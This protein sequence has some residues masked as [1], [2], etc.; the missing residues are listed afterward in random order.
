[1]KLLALKVSNHFTAIHYDDATWASWSLKSTTTLQFVRLWGEITGKQPHVVASSYAK[2]G[3]ISNEYSLMTFFPFRWDK[4]TQLRTRRRNGNIDLLHIVE[5][6]IHVSHTI[7]KQSI[8]LNC[9][10]IYVMGQ[11]SDPVK[12][13]SPWFLIHVIISLK[14]C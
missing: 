14:P 7:W 13:N 10:T 12:D 3:N 11:L 2:T 1:M 4:T 5:H 9:R 6:N 8:S